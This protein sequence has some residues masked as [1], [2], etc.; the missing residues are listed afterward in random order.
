MAPK[1]G[2]S[3]FKAQLLVGASPAHN[4]LQPGFRGSEMI[5]QSKLNDPFRL[6]EPEVTSGSDL[7]C[8]RVCCGEQLGVVKLG[9]I[10]GVEELGAKFY[11]VALRDLEAFLHN[12][13][14][15]VVP[16]ALDCALTCIAE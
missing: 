16:A 13:V 12:Q 5:L 10:E 1:A 7:A 4:P 6:C 8:Q 14:P 3:Q 9:V 2:G 15:F 11:F